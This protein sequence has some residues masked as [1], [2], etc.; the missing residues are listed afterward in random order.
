MSE[1]EERRKLLQQIESDRNTKA[2]LYVTGDR[3][4]LETMIGQDV[5]DLF[6]DHLDEIGPVKK[7]RDL[8]GRLLQKHTDKKDQ[9][10]QIVDFLCSESG[11]HDYTINRREAKRLGLNVEK[12]SEKLYIILRQLYNSFSTQMSL[13]EP[14]DINTLAADDSTG[15]YEFTRALIESVD[16]GAHHFISAGEIETTEITQPNQEGIPLKQIAIRDQRK[17]EGWRKIV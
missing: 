11:S 5:I 8:A 14:Y 12:C 9:I 6:V 15:K 16:Y 4:G 2:V 13:R 7:I 3:Q 1:I 10:D 17:F